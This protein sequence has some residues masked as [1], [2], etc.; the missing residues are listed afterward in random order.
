LT[1]GFSWPEYQQMHGQH[2]DL[3]LALNPQG[4]VLVASQ[5]LGFEPSTGWTL[6]ALINTP[7]ASSV[8]NPPAEKNGKEAAA[9]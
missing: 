1:N 7:P 8:T 2:A 4:H 3:L 9:G 6:V 5:P